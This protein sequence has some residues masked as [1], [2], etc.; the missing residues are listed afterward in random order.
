[1]GLAIILLPEVDSQNLAS[2]P[3]GHHPI[4][5]LLDCDEDGPVPSRPAQR[6]KRGLSGTDQASE[7]DSGRPK[8]RVRVLYG[9]FWCV[10]VLQ[11]PLLTREPENSISGRRPVWVLHHSPIVQCLN[12]LV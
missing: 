2:N 9:S 11:H 6:P 12:V 4:R 8:K 5:R 7:I 3:E 1:M 10:A